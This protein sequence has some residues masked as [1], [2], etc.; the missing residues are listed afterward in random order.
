MTGECGS[1][2]LDRE[3]IG[4]GLCDACRSRFRR[5]GT[6]TEWGWTRADRAA[7]FAALRWGGVRIPVAASRIGVS[8]RTAWR[9]EAAL[10]SAPGPRSS[11]WPAS[12]SEAAA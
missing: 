2:G 6:I 7:D 4:R 10:R 9:Y 12:R 5:A 3:I 11:G 1:C 8:E